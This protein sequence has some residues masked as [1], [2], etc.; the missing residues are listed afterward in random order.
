MKWF[1]NLKI[2]SKLV[3]SFSLI[4]LVVIGVTAGMF[5][6]SLM[7]TNN[8]TYLEAYPRARRMQLNEITIHFRTAQQYLLEMSAHHGQPAVEQQFNRLARLIGAEIEEITDVVSRFRASVNS[9]PRLG[10]YTIGRATGFREPQLYLADIDGIVQLVNE[11]Q[12]QVATPVINAHRAGQP[13]LAAEIVIQTA[14]LSERLISDLHELKEVTNQAINTS[15]AET[16]SFAFQVIFIIIALTLGVI[17]LTV[18]IMFVLNRTLS[19]PIRKVMAALGE[20][21]QG[22]LDVNL[23]MSSLSRDEIGELTGNVLGM[24]YVIKSVVDDLAEFERMYNVDGDIEYRMDAEKYQ[25]SFK[26]MVAGSN[27]VVDNIVN[28]VLGFLDTLSEVN[29][30]NFNPKIAKLPGKKIVLENAIKSTTENMIAINKEINAMIESVAVRGDLSFQINA[31]DYKGDWREIMAGLN[32]I[33]AAVGTPIN[34][35]SVAMREMKAGNFNL[36]SI[37]NK[38]AASGLDANTSN[39][40][41]VFKDIMSVFEDTISETASYIDEL[42]S[43]LAQMADGDLRH[44]IERQYV[45][46]FDLIKRSVNNISETL[47]KT[48]SEIST[49]A[50][51]VLSGAGQ[52][53]TSA[54]DLSSGAQEQASSVEELN[55][56]ID[57]ISQQTK[58]N[59]DDAAE[60]GNLSIKSTESAKAGNDAME[61]MLDA[62][63]QI[64]ESSNSISSINK[65]IQDIAFQTNLLA[66]NAAVEA[67]RAGEH[68]KGFSVVAEEVRSLAARSQEAAQE[69][70]GL[71][72]DSITR[73]EAGS[74][75]AK[76]TAE[77]LGIIVNNANEVLQ[78]INGISV[79]SKEQAEAVGQVSKGIGQISSV[80]Q[81]NSAVSEETAAA[82]E[83]LN[84]QSEMLRQLVSFFKL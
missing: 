11:W 37:D 32:S 2:R 8:F 53:S 16:T 31:G 18:V 13:G 72:A 35:V 59:A 19:M 76:T 36:T 50:D 57:L 54:T 49:A 45:G 9:D 42:D 79:S 20:V 22:K 27:K 56:S 25:N 39:Y 65:V 66:L 84:S 34:V 74:D 68:G 52:I 55:A 43:I 14:H 63:L 17:L 47:Y 51:H 82:S 77:A 7:A 26:D 46:S 15:A 58:Q 73:V 61:Q 40:R 78:I 4:I 38:I 24:V 6:L 80:V 41:G 23:D 5:V 1:S 21:S 30:G 70:T 12:G 48:M 67:A 71:I 81:N 29:D 33:A 3:V 60:A 10:N 44:R 83:E 69:T 28:D 62:M 64:K 75:I